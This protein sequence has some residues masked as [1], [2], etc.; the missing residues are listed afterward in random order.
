MKELLFPALYLLQPVQAQN[1]SSR[2]FEIEFFCFTDVTLKCAERKWKKRF[3]VSQSGVL[4]FWFPPILLIL[5]QR[6]IVAR[7]ARTITCFF[8]SSHLTKCLGNRNQRE[9]NVETWR[10]A[11]LLQK[12]KKPFPACLSFVK[13]L[14]SKLAFGLCSSKYKLK[15]DFYFTWDTFCRLFSFTYINKNSIARSCEWMKSLMSENAI[16]RFWGIYMW[17]KVYFYLKALSV[18]GWKISIKRF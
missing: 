3:I 14:W 7:S 9:Q 8:F 4:S 10:A 11:A 2:R 13:R 17:G 16:H 12:G 15:S 6:N 5:S 18:A 1:K